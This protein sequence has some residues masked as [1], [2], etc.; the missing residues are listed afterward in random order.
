[1]ANQASGAAS[2]D[3]NRRGSAGVR[4]RSRRGPRTGGFWRRAAVRRV[5]LLLAGVLAAVAPA[6]A[7]D[8]VLVRDLDSSPPP[9]GP[10]SSAGSE[11]MTFQGEL[12]FQGCTG[13]D[14][15]LWKTGASEVRLSVQES[16]KARSR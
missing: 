2:F 11:F 7:E 15:E 9:L 13:F 4:K 5:Q 10:V 8:L 6:P 14:C 3:A 16:K 12:Y 1:M